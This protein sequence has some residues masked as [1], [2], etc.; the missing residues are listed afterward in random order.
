MRTLVDIPDRQ[1]EDLATLS[2]AKK[3]PRAELI[4]QAIAAYIV[5]NKA[6][7]MD[8]FGLWQDSGGQCEDGL[9]YQERLRAEW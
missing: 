6:S 9:A 4:R 2:A 5:L 1:I 3:L 7:D 8:V